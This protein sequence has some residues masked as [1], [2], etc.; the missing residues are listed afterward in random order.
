MSTP[1]ST[2]NPYTPTPGDD[3]DDGIG[4]FQDDNALE[5]GS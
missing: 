3:D 4:S 1:L 2:P 5:D